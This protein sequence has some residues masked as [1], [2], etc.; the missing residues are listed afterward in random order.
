MEV[1]M[2]GG[3]PVLGLVERGRFRPLTAAAPSGS[4]RLTS[5]APQAA[6]APEGDELD[7]AEYEGSAI[8]VAGHNQGD[9]IYSAEVIDKATPIVTELVRRS[10][11]SKHVD[12]T[13]L[14][15]P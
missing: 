11:E 9:W 14:P 15:N 2:N 4:V 10:F 6:Q 5:I 12:Q 7:L 8:M 3:D 13:Y 1:Q